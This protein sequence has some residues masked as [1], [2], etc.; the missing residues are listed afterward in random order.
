[1]I[2]FSVP[3][4]KCWM[5][6]GSTSAMGENLLFV[7]DGIGEIIDDRKETNSSLVEKSCK[8]LKLAKGSIRPADKLV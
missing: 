2:E 5:R 3:K 8:T 1:M 7:D 4:T 6:F